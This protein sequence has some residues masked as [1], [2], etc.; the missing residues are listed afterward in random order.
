MESKVLPIESVLVVNEFLD[1]FPNDL[2]GVP[3]K[4]KI[5]FGIDLF[6]DTQPISIPPYR[7]APVELKEQ[8]RDLL[9][10]SCITP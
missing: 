3:P 8:L 6:L 1:V 10:K 4:K 9:E 7:M 2:P 5:D